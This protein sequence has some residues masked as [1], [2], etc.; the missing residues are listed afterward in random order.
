[1]ELALVGWRRG[2]AQVG[3]ELNLREAIA[4]AFLRHGR[5][6]AAHL[7][8]G[9]GAIG[10]AA[11]F[12][13]QPQHRRQILHALDD[14]VDDAGLV[15]Q[16]AGRGD[17]ARADDDRAQALEGLRPNDEIGDARLVLQRHEDHPLGGAGALAHQHQA[18]DRDALAAL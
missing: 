6:R 11:L 18:G 7:V 15:L 8:G 10:A 13:E 12:R 3:E 4:L 5:W 17:E 2:E 1:M 14:E 16:L 9:L